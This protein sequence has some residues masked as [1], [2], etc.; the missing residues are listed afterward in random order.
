M[1][2]KLEARIPPPL[3]MLLFGVAIWTIDRSLPRT[4]F[5]SE[6][7]ATEIRLGVAI[8]G[9]L[10]A[11]YLFAD[12]VISFRRAQT[13]IN[14]HRPGTT[15]VLVTGGVFN[16]SRNPIYLAMLLLLVSW[17]IWLGNSGALVLCV[18]FVLM[19]NRLQIIPEERAL[20]ELFGDQFNDY[21]QRVRRWI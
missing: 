2:D 3:L 13:T 1:M 12:A 10:V 21:Q 19:M 15:S 20:A 11:A 18:L 6:W 14:P 9:G 5:G 17:G 7:V 16:I 4:R 8:V